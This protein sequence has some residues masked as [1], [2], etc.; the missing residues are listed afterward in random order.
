MHNAELE[1][2]FREYETEC[3]HRSG[4]GAFV[5]QLQEVAGEAIVRRLM[6]GFALQLVKPTK[7]A[8]GK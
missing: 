7:L 2:Y 8:A 4:H 6:S 5:A 3:G 1:W